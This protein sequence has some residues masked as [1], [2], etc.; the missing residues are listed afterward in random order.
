ML[1]LFSSE[2]EEASVTL[3]AAVS[4]DVGPMDLPVDAVRQVLVNLVENAIRAAAGGGR[5]TISASVDDDRRLILHVDDD[6]HG[7]PEERRDQIFNPFFTTRADGTGLGLA[8]VRQV[9]EREGGDVMMSSREP[10]GTRFTV[11]VPTEPGND[12]G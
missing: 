5:V 7:V 4:A 2:A 9:L 10:R 1:V 12:D 6:G 3:D 11:T 8:I